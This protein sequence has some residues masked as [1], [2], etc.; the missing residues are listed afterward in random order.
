MIR[1]PTTI[2]SP[3]PRGTTSS[4]PW[5]N[6]SVKTTTQ[7]WASTKHSPPRSPTSPSSRPPL[8]TPNSS[9]AQP[10][11]AVGQMVAT[12]IV[13]RSSLTSRAAPPKKARSYS[14]GRQVPK[15]T[16]S[17]YQR[18]KRLNFIKKKTKRQIKTKKTIKPK[19]SLKALRN[20]NHSLA[21][22]MKTPSLRRST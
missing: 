6:A 9:S 5:T 8:T 4:K 18:F 14:K 19:N 17:R 7:H 21:L 12:P 13:S 3:L 1:F 20:A 2:S 16:R 10:T 22:V 11:T 15:I